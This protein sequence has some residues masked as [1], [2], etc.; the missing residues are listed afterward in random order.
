LPRRFAPRNDK[1]YSPLYL[2]SCK[3]EVKT[4]PVDEKYLKKILTTA[5]AV[6]K[7]KDRFPLPRE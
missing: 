6:I 4:Q 2:V 1:K 3:K 5:T 7:D